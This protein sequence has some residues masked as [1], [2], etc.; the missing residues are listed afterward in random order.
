[1]NIPLE[2]HNPCFI[3]DEITISSK[4]IDKSESTKIIKIESTITNNKN[5]V[6]LSGIGRI[7]VTDD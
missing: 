7:M 6:L 5:E 4:V 3:N 2:F 1:M